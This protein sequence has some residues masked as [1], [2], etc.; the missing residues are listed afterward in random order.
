MLKAKGLKA[1]IVSI[2]I[3]ILYLYFWQDPQFSTKSNNLF[4]YNESSFEVSVF[5]VTCLNS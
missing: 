5:S 4:I 3:C 1:K 2:R